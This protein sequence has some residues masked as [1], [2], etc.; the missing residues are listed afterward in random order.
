MNETNATKGK[1]K[2]IEG[3]LLMDEERKEVVRTMVENYYTQL[4]ATGEESDVTLEDYLRNLGLTRKEIKYG[5]SL[6]EDT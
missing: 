4:K 3:P 5:L 2:R 6:S 1:M